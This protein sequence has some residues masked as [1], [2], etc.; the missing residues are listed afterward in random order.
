MLGYSYVSRL[1]DYLL[2]PDQVNFNLAMTGHSV[3]VYGLCGMKF[4][5]QDETVHSL[6]RSKQVGA[7]VVYTFCVGVETEY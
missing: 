6:K 2:A 1:R 4:A 7:N 3:N 5:M